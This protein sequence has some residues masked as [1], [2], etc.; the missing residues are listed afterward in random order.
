M[1]SLQECFLEW[2]AVMSADLRCALTVSA[3]STRRGKPMS[4]R[5]GPRPRRRDEGLESKSLK[6]ATETAVVNFYSR[7]KGQLVCE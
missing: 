3:V 4:R 1:L 5:A 7:T 2:P 6:Q